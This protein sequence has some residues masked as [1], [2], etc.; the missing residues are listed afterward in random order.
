MPNLQFGYEYF[1]RSCARVD[2]DMAANSVEDGAVRADLEHRVGYVF[3]V[4][5][6][7]KVVVP[8]VPQGRVQRQLGALAI[9]E[10]GM[11]KAADVANT[12][13]FDVNIARRVSID[14]EESVPK[15][16]FLRTEPAAAPRGKWP[17]LEHP[18]MSQQQLCQT[19]ELLS[20]MPRATP[21]NLGFKCLLPVQVLG[22]TSPC[23]ELPLDRFVVI[24]PFLWRWSSFSL[25]SAMSY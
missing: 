7:A 24:S 25:W 18:P 15:A 1:G 14:V 12:V 11:L 16:R 13:S 20:G 5:G 22:H 3:P 9:N 8:F 6:D 2:A 4:Q 17:L 21:G 19:G 23:V 10:P